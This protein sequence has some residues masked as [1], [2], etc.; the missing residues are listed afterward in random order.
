MASLCVWQ[1][2]CGAIFLLIDRARH[3]QSADTMLSAGLR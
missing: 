1:T 3:P 2:S